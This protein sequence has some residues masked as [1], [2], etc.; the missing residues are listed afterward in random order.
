VEADW[1]AATA[2]EAAAAV[3]VVVVEEA[4]EEDVVVVVVWWWWPALLGSRSTKTAKGEEAEEADTVRGT[5][6]VGKGIAVRGRMITENRLRPHEGRDVGTLPG[7]A[8]RL[9]LC[10]WGPGPLSL[11]PL[12]K[13]HTALSGQLRG[14]GARAKHELGHDKGT[15]RETH[16]AMHAER[17]HGNT[18]L[19]TAAPTRQ[20]WIPCMASNTKAETLLSLPPPVVVCRTTPQRD[21]EGGMWALGFG[22]WATRDAASAR[23][24]ILRGTWPSKHGSGAWSGNKSIVGCR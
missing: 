13:H 15:N 8:V 12:K 3:V 11:L 6:R 22:L 20:P 2:V 21:K 16:G 24:C 10:R 23:E 7:L 5:N 4:E 18:A 17:P 14:T 19:A 1:A 9:L